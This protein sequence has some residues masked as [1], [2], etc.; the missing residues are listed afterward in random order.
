MRLWRLKWS[1][2]RVA[3]AA[4]LVWVLGAA[5]HGRVA[6]RALRELPGFDFAAE[7]RR[8]ADEGRFAEALLAAETG[9][10]RTEGP[11]RA[12]LERLRAQ[13]VARRDSWWRRARDVG[14]G[15]ITGRGSTLEELLG[16]IGADMLVIGD[17]RDLVIEGGRLVAD[18]ETDE[19]VLLLSA[20][21]LATTAVPMADWGPAVLKVAR[22]T[23][24][25]S[26][27]LADWVVSAVRGGRVTEVGELYADVG[28]LA[29]RATP[30]V[31]VRVLAHADTPG[32]VKK[33]AEFAGERGGAWALYAG[34][35]DAAKAA[36]SG[37]AAARSAFTAAVAKGPAGVAFWRTPAARAAFRPHAVIGLAKGV[38]KGNV[39]RA[40][41]RMAEWLDASGWWLLPVAAAWLAAE[42]WVLACRGIWPDV[43]GSDLR[44]SV[45]GGPA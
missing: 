21:G 9:M 27:G 39:P 8:L 40:V 12:E 31:A 30:A 3:L 33:L 29:D 2:V 37:E 5:E 13:T 10:E 25:M 19:V 38:W 28:K 43:A 44:P 32:E 35:A 14:S 42:M 16:A 7:T 24:A 1:L 34:G 23:G 45:S 20:A 41:E 15:A 11:D 17:V 26:R 22:K 4:A 18:G 6:R 36:T